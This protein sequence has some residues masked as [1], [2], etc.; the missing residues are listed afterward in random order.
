MLPARAAAAS[1]SDACADAIRPT[2][3]VPLTSER[4]RHP[5]AAVDDEAWRQFSEWTT[6]AGGARHLRS[7]LRLSGMHCASCAGLIESLL[8]A[9]P[10]VRLA[11]VSPS[12]QRLTL[13]WSPA[14]VSLDALRQCLVGA[15]YDFAPDLAAPARE[16]RRREHRQALWR[17][18]VAGFLMMQ[19]MMLAWPSY[20]AAPGEMAAD[21]AALLRWGQWVLTLPVMLLSAGPFFRAAWTQLRGRRLGM[22]VPVALGLAVAFVAGSGATLDPGG[23]FGHEVYF[24]SITMFVTFLLGAHYLELR[25]RHRAAEALE[26]A[27]GALPDKIERLRADGLADWVAAD[28]LVAGDLVRVTAGQRVPADAI[29]EHGVSAADEALL[30][31]ES[32]AVPK[33]VGDVV[34]AG[35]LNLTGVLLLR[36]RQIGEDTR[37]AGIRQL[38]AQAFQERPSTPRV[39][40]RVAGWFLGTVLLLAGGAA[41]VWQFID[42]SKALAVSVAVLIVTCPCALSLAAPAAWVA[43]AGALAK[44]GLLLSRLDAIES[45]ADVDHVVMDKTGTLTDPAPRLL[46]RWPEAP[47]DDAIAAAALLAGGSHHPLSRA[48]MGVVGARPA[49]TGWRDIEEIGGRGLQG[50]D[51]AGRQWRLGAGT[52]S[53]TSAALAGD[54]MP[55]T[56]AQLVLSCDGLPR[57]AWQFDEALREGAR[58]AVSVWRERGLGVELLSGDAPPR[59]AAIAA[60]AGIRQWRG[61]ASPEDKLAHVTRLQDGGRHVLMIGDGINDAPVLARAHVSVAMGQGADL[62]KS[63]ADALLMGT[64]LEAIGAALDLACRTRRVVRQNL[65]WSALYNAVCVPLAL[66]GWLPPWAAG[67]GMAMSSMVVVANAA[68]L[69]NLR[70]V[71]TD[72]D[73]HIGA[74]VPARRG[75]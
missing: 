28:E 44:R 7:R 5:D 41:L 27:V 56:E 57:V 35:S 1:A 4:A 72:V 69:G 17:L 13:D 70:R 42:P 32:D 47:D 64:R 19:V 2:A 46:R 67:L 73:A 21:Q 37:L 38:M 31:G 58:A 33:S 24:D 50:V 75:A 71:D 23:P 10:G 3:D 51:T 8:H 11:H 30:T 25:A 49:A 52:W 45:L 55:L 53:A 39:A 15:G 16:L 68:R 14:L 66:I 62:A 59:V 61:G 20:V 18:F 60:R 6:D 48:L 36:V 65:A 9:Q 26:Q 29:V 40:D 63:R 34:L 43:A 54:T 74:R 22:D 12:T